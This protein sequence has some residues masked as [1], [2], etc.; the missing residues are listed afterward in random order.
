MQI[1]LRTFKTVSS[2]SFTLCRDEKRATFYHDMLT[3]LT[4]AAY[5]TSS[6]WHAAVIVFLSFY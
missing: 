6:T 1:L 4:G 2:N 3:Y 5:G